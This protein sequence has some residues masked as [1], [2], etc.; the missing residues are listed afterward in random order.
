MH[1][2]VIREREKERLEKEQAR[3]A[4]VNVEPCELCELSKKRIVP[5][6]E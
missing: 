3:D 4:A 2:N 1:Q 5:E 6:D